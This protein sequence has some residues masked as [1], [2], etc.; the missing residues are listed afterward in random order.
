MGFVV[1]YWKINYF[2][3]I[4]P[5]FDLGNELKVGPDSIRAQAFEAVGMW[6]YLS[7]LLDQRGEATSDLLLFGHADLD[8]L[9]GFSPGGSAA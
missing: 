5:V 9:L 6:E 2:S 3:T 7:S 8:H 4:F 1:R